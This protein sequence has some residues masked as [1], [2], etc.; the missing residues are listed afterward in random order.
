M[1]I[2]DVLTGA[3]TWCQGHSAVDRDGVLCNFQAPEACRRCLHGAVYKV[4]Y[5]DSN[6]LLSKVNLRIY[7]LVDGLRTTCLRLYG[8]L[9]YINWQ[10]EPG[11]TWE[12]VEAL[13]RE[14]EVVDD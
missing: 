14:S 12:E 4:A 11:R 6:G 2:S 13:I 7:E 10:E 1:K 8:E 5:S 3:D 9:D